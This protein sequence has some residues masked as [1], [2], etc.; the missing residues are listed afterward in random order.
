VLGAIVANASVVAPDAS[1]AAHRAASTNGVATAYWSGAAMMAIMAVVA[2]V[3]LRRRGEG[4]RVNP[5]ARPDR[6]DR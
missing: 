4:A 6:G 1:A 5:A 2:L 3:W